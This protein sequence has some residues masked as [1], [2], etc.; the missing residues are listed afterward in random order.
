MQARRRGYPTLADPMADDGPADAARPAGPTA[1][2]DLSL[3]LRP[4]RRTYHT[5]GLYFGMSAPRAVVFGSLT[6]CVSPHGVT[7]QLRISPHGALPPSSPGVPFAL[8]SAVCFGVLA[9]AGVLTDDL[10]IV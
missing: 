9:V 2:A 5:V 1:A 4:L 7:R 6:P 8:V 10:Q 3:T